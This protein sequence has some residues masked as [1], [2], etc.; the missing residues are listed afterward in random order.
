M[1]KKELA[2]LLDISPAMVS[3]L[4][5]QGMP[6][7]TVERAKRWRK[8]HLEPSRIKG[9]RFDANALPVSV[10]LEEP[11]STFVEVARVAVLTNTAL[12]NANDT[13]FDA[14]KLLEPLRVMLQQLPDNARPRIPL[15]VWLALV[16][17]VL[18]EKSAL[19]Q[20]TDL[21]SVL[22]PDEFSARTGAQISG[23]SW[24]EL[25]CD[26]SVFSITGFPEVDLDSSDLEIH[27]ER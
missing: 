23:R 21:E 24:L 6:V 26:F 11:P 9:S 19:R 1:L 17:W 8:R 10:K 12:A 13:D 20:A 22:N 16:D 4:A 27:A 3:R 14:N 7:D 18:S 5:K 2:A 25:A 15:R